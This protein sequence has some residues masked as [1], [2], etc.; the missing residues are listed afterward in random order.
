MSLSYIQPIEEDVVAQ[1]LAQISYLSPG[2][3]GTCEAVADIETAKRMLNVTPP[4]AYVKYNGEDANAPKNVG[5]PSHQV[6]RFKFRIGVVA[7]SFSSQGEG[8]V[9]GHHD[10]GAFGMLD[11]V[12]AA[13]E[14]YVLPHAP[15]TSKL[16][17]VGN[18]EP[19]IDGL[20]VTA[21]SYWYCD[22]T[23]TQVI[24]A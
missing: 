1:L 6:S 11:D 17:F 24:Q 7:M 15:T 20:R 2:R 22:V 4:A 14:G 8:R 23:R 10:H 13:L 21:E 16:F 18:S 9:D 5:P 3:G 19:Q 12:F